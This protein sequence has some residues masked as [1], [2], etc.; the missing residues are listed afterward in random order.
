MRLAQLLDLDLLREGRRRRTL[1]ACSPS[2]SG[3]RWPCGPGTL[4]AT[5][6]PSAGFKVTFLHAAPFIRH[7]YR[8]TPNSLY[9]GHAITDI[10]LV[11]KDINGQGSLRTTLSLDTK[12][13]LLSGASA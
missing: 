13:Q 11:W 6:A 7:L 1:E 10:V 8:H 3:T 2:R 5:P 4:S 12:G 9:N